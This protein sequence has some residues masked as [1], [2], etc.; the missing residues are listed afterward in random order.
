MPQKDAGPRME[1]PVHEPRAPI[2]CPEATADP[3]PLEE[4]PVM[5]AKFHG[6]RAGSKGVVAVTAPPLRLLA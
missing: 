2:A 5:W 3:E 1:P 4:P 6:L